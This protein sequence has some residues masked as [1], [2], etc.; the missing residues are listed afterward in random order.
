M[1]VRPSN[2][3]TDRRSDLFA[4]AFLFS[5][6]VQ[7]VKV[8]SICG[9]L[10]RSDLFVRTHCDVLGVPVIRPSQAQSQVLLGAAILGAASAASAKEGEKNPR[11]TVAV[12]HFYL[13]RSR[14]L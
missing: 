1:S 14:R 2:G 3:Q 4:S 5:A 13:R 7:S 9:G 6:G 12:L 11:I 10:S 8:L